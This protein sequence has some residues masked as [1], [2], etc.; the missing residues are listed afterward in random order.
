[1]L[2]VIAIIGIL[3]GIGMNGYRSQRDNFIF[4][5]SLSRVLTLIKTA[6]NYAITSRAAYIDGVATIPPDGYGV[7]IRR[8]G[9]PGQSVLTL[10]ANTGNTDANANRFDPADHVEETYTLPIQTNFEALLKN[11]KTTAIDGSEAVIIFRPPLANTFISNNQ[12]PD[13]PVNTLF[14]QFTN[15]ATAATQRKHFISI[16][17]TAGFPELEL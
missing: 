2:L 14:M 7:D 12:A 16:N 6:R 1:M 13:D 5:D 17:R 10:F 9:T 15:R 4:N 3:F 11:D 8:S